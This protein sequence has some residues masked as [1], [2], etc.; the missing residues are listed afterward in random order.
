MVVEYFRMWELV[1]RI[2][3]NILEGNMLCSL[4]FIFCR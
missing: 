4:G 3:G 1:L 2:L